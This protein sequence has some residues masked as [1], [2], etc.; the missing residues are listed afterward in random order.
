MDGSHI[1]IPTILKIGGGTLEQIGTNIK[2]NGINNAVIYFGN[3]LIDSLTGRFRTVFKIKSG[4][5]TT[6]IALHRI[7]ISLIG[8]QALM[9][10]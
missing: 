2:A 1:S 4:D 9:Y 3:G 6:V 10:P 8:A 7:Q 5:F